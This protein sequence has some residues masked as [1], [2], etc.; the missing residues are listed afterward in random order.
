MMAL[1][2]LVCR[3]LYFHKIKS[4]QKSLLQGVSG[5]KNIKNVTVAD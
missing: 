3:F 4:C 1:V 5:E 2:L